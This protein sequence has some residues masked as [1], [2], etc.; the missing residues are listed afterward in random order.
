MPDH[1]EKS[2]F[3][4]LENASKIVQY[5]VTTALAGAYMG[6]AQWNI[7]Y[8]PDWTRSNTAFAVMTHFLEDRV[9]L[10]DIWPQEELLWGGIFANPRFATDAVKTLPRA[11]ELTARWNVEA[12][13][14]ASDATKV[15]VIWS[16]TGL[17][18][19]Q[20]DQQGELVISDPSGLR[21]FDLTGREIL[22]VGGRFVL[23]FT[24]VPVYITTE[25]LS[26]IE[27]RDRIAFG[28]LF[29]RLPRSTCMRFRS[30][31][32]R[33]KNR[34]LFVRIE[35]Q[36]NRPMK[37]SLTLRIDQSNE[38]TSTRFK[39]EAGRLAEVQIGWPGIA[40]SAENRYPITL[41]ARLDDDHLLQTSRRSF[42]IK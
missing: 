29:S 21:A 20:L 23:P 12:R 41:T 32:T 24:R 15:A 11:S 39:V 26:V 1:W 38:Q 35:N 4:N 5:Y 40:V 16:L 27:L 25:S 28:A 37:G 17:S 13:E 9:P 18:N 7:G 3:N 30:L 19:T 10:A 31:E 34:L 33:V 8:G 36:L 22:P 2:P 42:V 14:R 6:N